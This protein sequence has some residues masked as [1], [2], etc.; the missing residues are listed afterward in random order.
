MPCNRA[1]AT[2]VATLVMS[3]DVYVVMMCI[4]MCM[5]DVALMS[6]SAEDGTL[7]KHWGVLCPVVPTPSVRSWPGDH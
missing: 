2:F 4:V 6:S 5:I 7:V 1:K 3:Y